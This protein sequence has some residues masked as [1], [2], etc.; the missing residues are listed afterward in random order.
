MYPRFDDLY[1]GKNVIWEG[2]AVQIRESQGMML[3]GKSPGMIFTRMDPSQNPQR[4][5]LVLLF[6]SRTEAKVAQLEPG[7]FLKFNAQ[8]AT[9]GKRGAPHVLQLWEILESHKPVPV[10]PEDG[11]AD[12]ANF[13]MGAFGGPFGGGPGSISVMSGPG[14]TR[15]RVISSPSIIFR[16]G[17]D[18]D[19]PSGERRPEIEGGDENGG[20][21]GDD[22]DAAEARARAE[23]MR[24]QTSGGE[25]SGDGNGVP[26]A[27]AFP[28]PAA[29]AGG[30]EDDL[31]N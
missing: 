27:D 26:D 28:P 14:V 6:D 10:E 29:P 8:F 3:W 18:S 13:I 17:P 19:G 12:F 21:G 15:I 9:I 23:A 22:E 5:D 2:Q 16:E 24:E 7:H 31:E 4:Q 30:A 11:L 25:A 1:H 20:G